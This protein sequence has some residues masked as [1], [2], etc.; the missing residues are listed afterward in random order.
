[1]CLIFTGCS[2][3]MEVVEKDATEKLQES[4]LSPYIEEASY[5]VANRNKDET[6]MY[7]FDYLLNLFNEKVNWVHKV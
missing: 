6:S 2:A 5:K 3:D 7:R 4:K 1:M